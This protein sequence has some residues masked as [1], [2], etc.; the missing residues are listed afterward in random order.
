MNRETLE[1]TPEGRAVVADRPGAG[2]QSEAV[3][4]G[5]RKRL[6]GN[7]FSRTET[8]GPAAMLV[9]LCSFFAFASDGF[10]GMG[11]IQAI[12]NQAAVP[13]VLASGLT[14]VILMGSI[15]MS[16]EGVI[17]TVSI[18]SAMLVSNSVNSNHLG[19]IA[20]VIALAIGAG[21]GLANGLIITKLRLPSL[22]VTLGMW[23]VGLGVASFLFPDNQP[24]VLDEGFRR[25]ALDAPLGFQRLTYVAVAVV[26]AVY[27]VLKWTRLG[28]TIYA[29][30]AGEPQLVLA[31]VNVDR[32]KIAAFAASGFLAGLAALMT[33]A[34]IGGGDAA[35]GDGRLFPAVSAVVIGGTLL[36]GGRGGVLQSVVGVLLLAVL[37][38]GMMHLGVSVYLQQAMVG[39]VVVAVVIVAGWQSRAVLRVIK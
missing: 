3:A 6:S 33:T 32:Y 5:R 18:L 28:R 38:N 35:A 22:I 14:L 20:T 39:L 17:A 29:I 8:W 37:E 11:N 7:L 36:S 25:W 1:F 27:F 9:L 19:R 31:G 21:F 10:L 24:R 13:I 23:F 15:D 26:L 34:Q 2:E 4:L 16:I 30:G 12:A